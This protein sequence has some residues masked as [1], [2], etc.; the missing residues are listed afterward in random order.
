MF[1]LNYLEDVQ[2]GVMAYSLEKYIIVSR[3]FSVTDGRAA[4][5]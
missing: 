5:G 2:A 3:Y 4:I 1:A